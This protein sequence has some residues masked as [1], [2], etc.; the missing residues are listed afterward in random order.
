MSLSFLTD[1]M[2]MQLFGA[3]LDEAEGEKLPAHLNLCACYLKMERHHDAMDQANRALGV[4]PTNAKAFY[5][6]GK[7]RR[8]L[9]QDEDARADLLK[10]LGFSEGASDPAIEREL[11]ALDGERG[12]RA[13]RGAACGAGCSIPP[14]TRASTSTGRRSGSTTSTRLA[15]NQKKETRRGDA[16]VTAGSSAGCSNGSGSCRTC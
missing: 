12:V 5:R 6:R 1:D 8:A 9:G 11:A 4:D 14:T 10:A 2:M 3:Y 16:G 13:T 7:A 15:K